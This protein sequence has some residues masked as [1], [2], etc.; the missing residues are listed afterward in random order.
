M[1]YCALLSLWP[2]ILVLSIAV[3][4]EVARALPA[5]DGAKA[6]DRVETQCGFGPRVPGTAGHLRCLD[7]ILAEIETAGLSPERFDF[8]LPAPATGDT[9]DL[10]NV[11]VRIAPDRTPRLLLGAHWDTRPWSDQETD[12]ALR[13][14]PVSG[15]NDGASGV[16]VLL[17]LADLL[18]AERPGIGVDLAFFDGEDQGRSGSPFEYCLGSQWMA[19]HW[20][21]PRP[22]YVLVLDMVGTPDSDLGR[23]IVSVRAHPEWN[24]LIVQVAESRGYSEFDRSRVY[25]VFDDHIPFLQLGIP[26]AVVIGFDDP[27]WHTQR[28]VPA[29]VSAERLRRVGEV[30]LEIVL[31][32]YL[33]PMGTDVR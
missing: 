22:D 16:A 24:D 23:D 30:A 9:L 2:G 14:L 31:G 1:R 8:R 32:G 21:G 20:I 15:A 3:L 27:N 11:I 33:G 4:P 12:P 10:T 13:E 17:G 19:G 18:A 7:W 6:F 29:A 28:D 5:F 25:N 26:S